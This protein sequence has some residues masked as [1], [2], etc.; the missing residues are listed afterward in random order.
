MNIGF[1]GSRTLFDER[2]E[3]IILEEI[4]KHEPEYVVTHGEPGGVCEVVRKVCKKHA[5]PL[6]LHHLNFKKLRGAFEWRSKAVIN[7]SD[8][9][10]LIWDGISKGTT[11]ELK[12][13]QKANKPYV[14]HE[15]EIPKHTKSIGFDDDWGG[16]DSLEDIKL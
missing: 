10:V 13:I 14:L 12:L 11:N 6:I 5:I 9:S 4:K 2:V 1:H 15:L 8:W 3:I 16:I 7:D